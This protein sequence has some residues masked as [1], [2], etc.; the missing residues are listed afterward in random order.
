MKKRTFDTDFTS[1]LDITIILLFFFIIYSRL[2]TNQSQSN[3]EQTMKEAQE[4]L[5]NAEQMM[6][7]AEELHQTAEAL[8]QEADR[9]LAILEEADQNAAAMADAFEQFRKGENCISLIVQL[10]GEQTMVEMHRSGQCLNKW[11]ESAISKKVLCD[12]FIEAG[13]EKD[14]YIFC[15]FIYYSNENGSHK[16]VR[17]LRTYLKDVQREFKNLYQSETDLNPE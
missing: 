8:Q 2:D 5:S 1:L 15:N 3:A 9:Q 6:Q 16:P 17:D 10:D 7:D 4:V 12:A 11:K 14:S 13:Y